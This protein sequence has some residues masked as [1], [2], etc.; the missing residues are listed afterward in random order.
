MSVKS[1]TRSSGF[2]I[3]AALGCVATLSACSS[4]D[5]GN[6]AASLVREYLTDKVSGKGNAA[7]KRVSPEQIKQVAAQSAQP[8]VLID[9]ANTGNN[10]LIAEIERNGPVHTYATSARQTVSFE[11]GLV[12]GTRGLGGDLM[13]VELGSLPELVARRHSGATRREMRFLNGE[14][15]TVRYQFTCSVQ[16]G[17]PSGQPRT[18]PMSESCTQTDGNIRFTNTYQV[19]GHGRVLNSRQ[20]LG[21]SLGD[22][23]V[24]QIKF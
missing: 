4:G 1:K 17:A 23:K 16:A 7:P 2:A 15:I 12:R 5:E 14:D 6:D 9:F 8:I 20:W 21:P 19:D 10:A 11:N 3:L 18:T 22:A 24:F 13:S